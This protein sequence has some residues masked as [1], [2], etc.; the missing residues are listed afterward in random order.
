MSFV[1]RNRGSRK[2]RALA[3]EKTVEAADFHRALAQKDRLR[4]TNTGAAARH[5]RWR[6]SKIRSAVNTIWISQLSL[7]ST[8]ELAF[9]AGI[10]YDFGTA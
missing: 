3:A 10:W 5:W 2:R 4:A 6:V 9:V 8:S 7:N 1:S